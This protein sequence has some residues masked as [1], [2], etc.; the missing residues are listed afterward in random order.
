MRCSKLLV[1]VN[2][3]GAIGAARA[4]QI[5]GFRSASPESYI[6]AGDK[7]K[8]REIES[9]N[10]GA[11]KVINLEDLHARLLSKQHQPIEYPLVV[12]PCMGWGSECVSKV[13][14][15]EELVQAVAREPPITASLGPELFRRLDQLFKLG[16]IIFTSVQVSVARSSLVTDKRV[17][18]THARKRR[19]TFDASIECGN[20]H[21]SFFLIR[22]CPSFHS[23]INRSPTP[24][25]FQ[26]WR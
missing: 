4:C 13:Q 18:F 1:T 14:T 7:F 8:T 19:Q 5:L 17:I 21:F 23:H 3:A 26:A 12:K 20:G 15:E 6:I 10:E 22:S 2:N 24:I 16:S 25:T 11:F 9:E